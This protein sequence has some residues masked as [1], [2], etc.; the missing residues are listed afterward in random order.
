MNIRKIVTYI[1]TLLLCASCGTKKQILIGYTTPKT[2]YHNGYP[3]YTGNPWVSNMSKPYK[4]TQGLA[5]KHVSVTNSHGRYFNNK[6]GEWDWQR[7]Y[8]N[9]TREDL[10]TRTIVVPY[11]IPM[12]ENAGA[13]VFTARER[14]SQTNE[15]IVEKGKELNIFATWQDCPTPGFADIKKVYDDNDHP[16]TY[17]TTKMVKTSKLKQCELQFVPRITKAGDYAVYVAYPK[18][19]NENVPDAHYTVYHGGTATEYI[20]NQTIGQG[21][22]VY[23]GTF[24]FEAGQNPN[25][26]VILTNESNY[27]GY[28]TANAVRFGGGMGRTKRG[29]RVSGEPRCVEAARYSAQWYGAPDRVWSTYKHENDY[30]DD[31]RTRPMMANWV[32]GGS[33]FNPKEDGLGVPLELVLAVHSDAGKTTDSSYIGTLGICTTNTNEGK[34]ASGASR[35]LSKELATNLQQN[36]YKDVVNKYGNWRTRGT[37][38]KNYGET[39][40]PEMPSAIVEVLSHENPADMEKGHDPEFRF[41]LAR[42]MYK[43]ILRFI[44]EQHG[45]KAIVQPLPVKNLEAF[46]LNNGKMQ[47]QWQAQLDETEPGSNPRAF[48]IYIAVGNGDYNN[49][50]VVKS[51]A[52]ALT[53]QPDAK[54]RIKVTALNDGGESMPREIEFK[55]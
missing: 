15:I 9:G 49:G 26:C 12:L 4:I 5:N 44:A 32:A 25:N 17:G 13:N 10:F 16:F 14:D 35:D 11:L 50:D 28:I 53:V 54:Y 8:M 18:Y 47:V 43:T 34:L 40:L 21:T 37:W 39:R 23:L 31:I 30:N 55:R 7:P 42:S 2:T 20:V 22:W 6:K 19:K 36:I 27:K 24:R 1:F 38:D 52:I 3:Q 46:P 33:C 45:E 48:I 41:T 51:N 29:G